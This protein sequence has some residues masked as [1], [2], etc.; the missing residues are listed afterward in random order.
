[1]LLV[2]GASLHCLVF[3]FSLVPG[4]GVLLV[5]GALDYEAGAEYRVELK[6]QNPGTALSSTATVLVRVIGVNEFT[7][8]FQVCNT[9]THLT[10]AYT[11][12]HTHTL[13]YTHTHTHTPRARHRRQRVHTQLPGV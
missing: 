4:A 8:N 11:Y 2:Q 9:H 12:A 6:A 13:V 10:H 7:P 5:Q 3:L 1:M